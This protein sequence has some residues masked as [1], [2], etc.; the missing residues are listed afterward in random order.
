[1]FDE[2]E[3]EGGR[4]GGERGREGREGGREGGRDE[5]ALHSRV[6]E[7]RP[8]EIQPFIPQTRHN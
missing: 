1:M 3:P 4:E 8:P 7:N 2:E 6:C 5:I